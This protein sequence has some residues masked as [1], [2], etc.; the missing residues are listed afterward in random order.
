MGARFSLSRLLA[1]LPAILL[2]TFFNV[3]ITSTV[4][5]FVMIQLAYL[6]Q[7][8]PYLRWIVLPVSIITAVAVYSWIVFNHKLRIYIKNQGETNE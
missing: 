5:G 2:L 4:A 6:T 1:A 3:F 8:H 7:G